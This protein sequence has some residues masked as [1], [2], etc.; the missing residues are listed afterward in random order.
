MHHKV[1]KDKT[2]SATSWNALKQITVYEPCQGPEDSQL[3]SC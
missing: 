2:K 3:H 1:T